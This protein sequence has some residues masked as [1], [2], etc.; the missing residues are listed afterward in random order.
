MSSSTQLEYERL[1]YSSDHLLD[2]VGLK[3][4]YAP[5]I[6]STG[7]NLRVLDVGCGT[8]AWALQFARS[9]TLSPLLTSS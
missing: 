1:N 4:C 5:L 6:R 2:E 8:G 7:Q 9:V 3:L